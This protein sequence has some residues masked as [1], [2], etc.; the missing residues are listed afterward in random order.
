MAVILGALLLAGREDEVIETEELSGDAAW[1]S[2]EVEEL[3]L[4]W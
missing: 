4:D 3:S 2:A 1:R